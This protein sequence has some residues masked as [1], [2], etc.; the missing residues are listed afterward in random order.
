MHLP[1]SCV[2]RS[3]VEVYKMARLR[4]LTTLAMISGLTSSSPLFA[5]P[6][7]YVD[8]SATGANNGSSWCD[9]YRYLQDAL[10]AARTQ[11]ATEIRVAA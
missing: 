5:Q 8:D 2:A 1:S 3:V 4:L 7:L 6:I 11:G 9:A 10:T